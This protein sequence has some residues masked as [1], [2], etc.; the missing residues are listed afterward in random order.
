MTT[1]IWRTRVVGVGLEPLSTSQPDD[2]RHHHVEHDQVG[3]VPADDL[4]R[5]AAVGRLDDLVAVEPE[6][7]ADELPDVGLVVDDEDRGQATSGSLLG[8]GVGLQRSRDPP[9]GVRGSRRASAASPAPSNA[10]SSSS[11]P[12]ARSTAAMNRSPCSYWF[13]LASSPRSCWSRRMPGLTGPAAGPQHAAEPLGRRDAVGAGPVHGHVAVALEQAHQPADLLE[14]LGLLGR[15]EQGGQA[16]VVERVAAGRG[17]VGDPAQR[18]AASRFGSGSTQPR[19]LLD[20][21]EEVRPQPRHAGELRPVGDLVEGQPQPELPGREG[22][23]LLEG[24]DVGADVVHEVLVVG[25]LVLDDEQVVLAEHPG[26]HP[27]EQRADLGA[28]DACGRPAR[29]GPTARRSPS[30]S[31]SGRSSRWNDATLARTQPA[32]S[33]TRARAGPASE[34]RP[35]S[36][37]T[38]SSASAVSSAKSGSSESAWYEPANGSRPGD[39]DGDAL[40][41]RPVDRRRARPAIRRYRRG[42]YFGR[43]TLAK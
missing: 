26:R 32:R 29:C 8:G 33:V 25:V 14:H 28:G 7:E 35:V 16:A 21:A 18:R 4:E 40:G 11:G 10:V 27:A 2:L 31:V 17:G 13:S 37:A 30:L 36:A 3:P 19:R 15:G 1:G 20:E 34:R 42:G 5:L 24:E 39:P 22:E 43:T 41:E 9:L 38:S 23:A 12:P 6:G